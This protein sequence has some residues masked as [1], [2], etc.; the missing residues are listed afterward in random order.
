MAESS[1]EI[2]YVAVVNDEEQYSIWAR[3]RD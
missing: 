3:G 2:T 1:D